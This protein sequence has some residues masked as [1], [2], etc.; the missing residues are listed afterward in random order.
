MLTKNEIAIICYGLYNTNIGPDF[1]TNEISLFIPS[2][3]SIH[4]TVLFCKFLIEEGYLNSF[5]NNYKKYYY[6]SH[7]GKKIAKKFKNS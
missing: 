5:T 7:K 6:L 2:H 1:T 4:Q 3:P